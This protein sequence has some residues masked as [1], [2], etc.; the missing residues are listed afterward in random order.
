MSYEMICFRDEGWFFLDD[1]ENCHSQ[2]TFS[3]LWSDPNP[4]IREPFDKL[5]HVLEF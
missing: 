1:I 3:S 4:E 2:V 5:Y